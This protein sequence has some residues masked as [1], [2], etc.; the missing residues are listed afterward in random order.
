MVAKPRCGDFVSLTHAFSA[1]AVNPTLWEG[2]MDAAAQ[3]TGSTGAALLPI[4]G[5]LPSVPISQSVGE[6]FAAYFRDGWYKTDPR[7]AGIPSLIRRGVMSDFDVGPPDEFV[8]TSIYRELCAPLGLRWVAGVKVAAGDDLWCLAIQRSA[9]E[10]PFGPQDIRRLSAVSQNLSAAAATARAF[11]F[12]RA[13]AALDVFE[14]SGSAVVLFDRSAEVFRLNRAAEHLLGDDLR[15]VHN[16]LVARDHDATANL[17]RALHALLWSPDGPSLRPPVTLPRQERYPILAYASRPT[18]VSADC[19]A[20]CQAIVV[21][22]DLEARV[23]LVEQDLMNTFGLTPAEARL[24]SRVSSGESIE[25]AAIE[26]GVTYETTRKHLKSI[27]QKTGTHRQAQMV[28]LLAHFSLS[29]RSSS[30]QK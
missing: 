16:R 18:G 27:F 24:A 17:D 10:G 21:L 25:E 30:D 23:R 8:R 13:E 5:H 28:A 7:Y 20:P 15:I 14:M 3:V 19:F 6:L 1:A 12:A 26:L 11:G 22:V 9:N 29:V 4:R 2:A